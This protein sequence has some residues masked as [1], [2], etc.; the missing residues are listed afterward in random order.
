MCKSAFCRCSVNKSEQMEILDLSSVNRVELL[1][2][3]KLFNFLLTLILL[4][5]C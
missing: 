5:H 3:R 4:Q 1:I 2:R